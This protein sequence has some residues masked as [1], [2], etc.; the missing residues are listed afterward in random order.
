MGSL[1]S[2]GSRSTV[3]T[4]LN[5]N[6]RGEQRL[7]LACG[8]LMKDRLD[9]QPKMIKDCLWGHVLQWRACKMTNVKASIRENYGGGHRPTSKITKTQICYISARAY[10]TNLLYEP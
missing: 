5:L 3:T 10:I 7:K 9:E 1:S 2:V 4:K 6:K 8:V